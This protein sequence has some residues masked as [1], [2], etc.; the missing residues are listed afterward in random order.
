MNK[1]LRQVVAA[2][3]VHTFTATGALWGL[4]SLLAIQQHQWQLSFIWIT[5]A[6]IVDGV[7]G[8]FARRARVK[9]Y[10][11][12]VD[13]ALLDNLIDYLNYVVVPSIFLIEAELVPAQ[14]A[15]PA[16]AMIMLTSAY[17]FSQVDAKTEDHFFLGFPSYWNVTVLYMLVLNLNPWFNLGA[18][19]FLGI[20][21]FVP[22]KYVYPTRTEKLQRLTLA[23]TYIWGIIGFWG[24]MQF[25]NTPPQLMWATLVYVA[26]YIAISVWPEPKSDQDIEIEIEAA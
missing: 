10:A 14:F 6:I 16:A 21:V 17:Q 8:W 18:L 5:L 23:L 26:Y 25:P 15:I 1:H 12:K 11:P 20:L 22:V 19:I 9:I 3:G 4:L 7:D 24:L 13:G 2:W